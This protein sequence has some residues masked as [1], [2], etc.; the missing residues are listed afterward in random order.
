[1]P[2]VTEAHL[3]A[4]RQEILEAAFAC[5]ARQ[6]FHLTTMQDICQEAGLSPGA[7]Y[8]YFTSKDELIEACC[9]SCQQAEI[10][11]SEATAQSG[12][13]RDILDELAKGPFSELEQPDADVRTRLII[14]WWSEV[15]RS[16]ELK[17]SLRSGSVDPLTRGLTEIVG[18]AQGLAEINPAL[19]AE[20]VARVL[21]STWQGLV[22]QKALDPDIEV[23][24]YLDAVKAMYSGT[25]WQG[26]AKGS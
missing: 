3:E 5:F 22:L 7:V 11:V 14:Q 26:D 2:K 16:P 18:R 9:E 23:G 4:R 10:A 12:D 6:G 21:L 13:T 1:M 19:N 20:A 15:M 17:E 8:R 24:P 25:F